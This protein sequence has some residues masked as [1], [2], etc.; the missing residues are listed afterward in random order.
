MFGLRL[1]SAVPVKQMIPRN[2]LQFIFRIA[3]VKFTTANN[4]N[5]YKIEILTRN[6]RHMGEMMKSLRKIECMYW[7]IDVLRIVVRNE[8]D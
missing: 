3:Y 8:I 7:V 5:E 6:L 1:S 2:A 4:P